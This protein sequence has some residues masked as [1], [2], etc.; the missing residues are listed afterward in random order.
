M[1]G[2]DVFHGTVVCRVLGRHALVNALVDL[3]GTLLGD[4]RWAICIFGAYS[5]LITALRQNVSHRC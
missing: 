1:S 4:A 2:E 5:L 3:G